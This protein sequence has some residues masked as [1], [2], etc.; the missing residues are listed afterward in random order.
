MTNK[1]CGMKNMQFKRS[2]LMKRMR[3]HRLSIRAAA[4]YI[5]TKPAKIQALLMTTRPVQ[6]SLVRKIARA[7][8][9][10]AEDYMEERHV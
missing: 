1:I 4:R 5:G 6:A 2:Q 10:E 9:D 3:E 8:Y 7:F